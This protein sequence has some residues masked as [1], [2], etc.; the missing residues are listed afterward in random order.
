M[1]DQ[2]YLLKLILNNRY[3]ALSRLLAVYSFHNPIYTR[4]LHLSVDTEN[5]NRLHCKYWTFRRR[6]I[7][8][9]DFCF[10]HR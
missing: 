4:F 7:I 6:S 9:F 1:M 3:I 8:K 2:F 10:Q 5:V